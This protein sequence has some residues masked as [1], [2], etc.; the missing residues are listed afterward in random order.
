MEYCPSLNSSIDLFSFFNFSQI[1]TFKKKDTLVAYLNSR[2][3]SRLNDSEIL[4]I[5]SSVCESVAYLHY[6]NPP[7]IHRDLKVYLFFFFFLTNSSFFYLVV[8][9]LMRSS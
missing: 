1:Q 6:Q 4:A 8:E 2:F 5:F 9:K 7:I 3:Q